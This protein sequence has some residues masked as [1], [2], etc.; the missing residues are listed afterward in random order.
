M[1]NSLTNINNIVSTFSIFDDLSVLLKLGKQTSGRKPTLSLSEIATISLIKS[2]YGIRN[3]KGLYKLLKSRFNRE[4]NLPVYKNFVSLMNKDAKLLLVLINTLLQFNQRKAGIIK[5]IDSTP[6]P[7][8]KNIRI[9]RHKTCKKIATRGRSSF[10][11]FYGLKL[12]AVTDLFGNLLMIKF[13]T[14]KTGDRKILD[15]FLDKLHSSII[16]ADAGYASKELERK[17]AKKGHFLLTCVKRNAKKLTTFLDICLLNLRP[18]IESVFSV[19]KERL[20]LVTSLPRSID[21]YLAHYIH[22]I[23]GYLMLK[24]IS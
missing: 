4:F 21:G 8:C 6:L 12:H 18:R 20:G 2:E 1:N 23:F 5:I 15:F 7:V 13:T 19:L 9:N 22:V 24:T 3:L 17:A 11:W 14:A 10:G 16:L